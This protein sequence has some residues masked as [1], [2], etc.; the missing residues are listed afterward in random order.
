M[1]SVCRAEN[2]FQCENLFHETEMT[3]PVLADDWIPTEGSLFLAIRSNCRHYWGWVKAR[4]ETLVDTVGIDNDLLTEGVVI[5]DPHAGN[6]ADLLIEG[7][8]RFRLVDIDD[9]GRGYFLFDIAKF[10]SASRAL[11]ATLS[12]R[13]IF[14]AYREGLAMKPRETPALI[15]E[16]LDVKTSTDIKRQKKFIQKM[17]RGRRLLLGGKVG[18]MK[19][20]DTPAASKSAVQAILTRAPKELAD[21]RV[22]DSAVRIKSTGGSRFVPRLWCLIEPIRKKKKARLQIV[23][24]KLLVEP[25]VALVAKQLTSAERVREVFSVYWKGETDPMYRIVEAGNYSFFMRLKTSFELSLDLAETEIELAATREAILYIAHHMGR[26][27][28]RQASGLI[29]RRAVEL[30]PDKTLQIVDQVAAAYL[31]EAARLHSADETGT[32]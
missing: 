22:V 15:R 14:A 11:D 2:G 16:A 7:K 9:S 25:A 26:M 8:R 21:F 10:I 32:H 1:T 27:V 18:L 13:A 6:F 31:V 19:L 23:E 29:F 30:E 24:F 20:E 5:G 3:K 17:V 28:A 12:T 4:L